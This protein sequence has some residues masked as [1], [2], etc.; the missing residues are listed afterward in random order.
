ML[1]NVKMPTIVSIYE[2]DKFRAQLSLAWKKVITS[3]PGLDFYCFLSNFPFFFIIMELVFTILKL[4][5][6]CS[7]FF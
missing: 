3:G 6:Q 5:I 7:L 1:M 2:H 4:I